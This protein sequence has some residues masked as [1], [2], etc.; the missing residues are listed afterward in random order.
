MNNTKPLYQQLNEERTNGQWNARE[1]TSFDEPFSIVNL[2]GNNLAIFRTSHNIGFN[3]IV[4]NKE[5]EANA[6]YT[7]LAVNNLHKLAEALQ[8]TLI[9]YRSACKLLAEANG[10]QWSEN[11]VSIKAEQALKSIS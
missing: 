3:I 6:A 7:C 10:M 2:H 4:D 9:E 1:M 11:N 5:A 8:E